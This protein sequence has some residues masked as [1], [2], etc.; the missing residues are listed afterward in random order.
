MR[1]NILNKG[2]DR[3][4]AGIVVAACACLLFSDTF[5]TW[6]MNTTQN[7]PFMAGFGK[8]ALLGTLGESLAQRLLTGRYLPPGF[9]P[10]ARA[11]LWGLLGV[12]IS[13]AF[14]I[15][16]AGAPCMLAA[17]GLDWAPRALT[18]PLGIRKVI[19]AFA[20]S[21]TMNTMFAPVL[22]V[23]H[24]IGDMRIAMVADGPRYP[25]EGF[26][27]GATLAEIDWNRMWDLVLYRSLLFFWVPAHTVTFLLPPAFR[28]LFAAVLGAVLGLILA[29]AAAREKKPA[30]PE[31]LL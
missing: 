2:A 14:I 26:N 24:K 19:T 31:V 6:Y 29:W 8:F 28:V 3:V 23:A 18:G 21:L 13:A 22:M 11:L 7:H 20:I 5:F 1:I 9:R 25:G 16:S 15:F 30:P 4:C 12:C 10:L 17:L 27:V